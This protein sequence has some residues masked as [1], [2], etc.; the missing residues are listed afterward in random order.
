MLEQGLASEIP[1]PGKGGLTFDAEGREGGPYHSRHFH[2]P[3]S[4]SG[5]TIGR[6][7]DMKLRSK[8]EIRD[9]LAEAGLDPT[10]AALISQAA[11]LAGG[12]AEEFIE[13]NDLEDFEITQEQQLK[14]FE[15][16][17]ARKAADT[18]RLATK[19]DVTR[20]YGATDWQALDP[21][22]MEVLVDLRFRGDYTPATRRFLQGCVANNDL[23]AF[24]RELG[25]QASWPGVPNDRF[26]R[27]K[28]V[29]EAALASAEGNV[30]ELP[31][32]QV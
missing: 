1:P 7:Y 23:E 2:V 30:A 20:L 28:A 10:V 18:R 32:D 3:S 12:Q 19:A 6:G 25:N 16:E 9:D 24:A 11:G 13:E 14:L 8:S 21:T 26:Q 27:R 31:E 22:I 4:G 15:V 17:Y 29:C 5:L